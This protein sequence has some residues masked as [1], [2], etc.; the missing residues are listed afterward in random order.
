MTSSRSP[1]SATYRYVERRKERRSFATI[2]PNVRRGRQRFIA[3]VALATVASVS[4]GAGAQ[5]DVPPRV[6]LIGDSVATPISWYAEARRSLG[7]SVDLRLEVGVCMR[8]TGR[9][10]PF[11]RRRAPTLVERVEALGSRLG[12]TVVVV[13][14]YNEFER[15]FAASVASSVDALLRAGVRHIIWATLRA[16]RHPYL[17]MNA[18]LWAAAAVHPEL[19]IADWNAYARSHPEWFQNDGIHL[20]RLGGVALAGLLRSRLAPTEAGPTIVRPAATLPP[21]AVGT[22]YA[23]RLVASAGTPPYRWSIV[24]GSPPAGLHLAPTG[25]LFGTPRKP[26]RFPFVLRVQDASAEVGLRRTE[27]SVGSAAAL[28]HESAPA[29]RPTSGVKSARRG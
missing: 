19:S 23:T 21:A 11:E 22:R 8:L 18:E 13:A 27:L 25:R 20:T 6:T 14:G 7:E 29:A 9:S 2:W 28:A 26:G 17:T 3:V 5:S 16:V 12:P 1:T 15:S 24:W 10:C 4:A